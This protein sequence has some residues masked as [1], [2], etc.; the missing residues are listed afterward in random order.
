MSREEHAWALN[1][2]D[3]V[4]KKHMPRVMAAVTI[5]IILSIIPWALYPLLLQTTHYFNPWF[6]A[7]PITLQVSHIRSLMFC[8]FLILLSRLPTFDP[9][10]VAS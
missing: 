9:C 3:A 6:I 1:E 10:V 8:W 5:Y 2:L 4:V 7:V